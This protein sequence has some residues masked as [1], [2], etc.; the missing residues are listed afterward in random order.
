MD[1]LKILNITDWHLDDIRPIGRK[2]NYMQTQLNQLNEVYDITIENNIDILLI[3]GDLFNRGRV[4]LPFFSKIS[5][6][7]QSFR[8][9][10]YVV[11][12][13]HDMYD[14]TIYT[15]NKTYLGLLAKLGIITL[16]THKNPVY[17]SYGAK[18]IGIQG[19]EYHSKID[20]DIQSYYYTGDKVDYSIVAVH[21]NLLDKIPMFSNYTLVEDILDTNANIVTSGHYHIGFKDIITDTKAIINPK[22]LCRIKRTAFAKT[23]IPYGLLIE[24]SIGE[25]ITHKIKKIELTKS[26]IS[27]EEC[28]IEGEIEEYKQEQNYISE[29]K[30]R[31]SSIN[32][33]DSEL[34]HE[35]TI[36]VIAKELELDDDILNKALK[37]VAIEQ[38]NIIENEGLEGYTTTNDRAILK[39]THLKNFM[40]YKDQT[41]NW[42]K[43]TNVLVGKSSHGKSTVIRA[44]KYNM[45]DERNTDVIRTGESR[46]SVINE[47]D[48]GEKVNR[49]MT[50]STTGKYTI[51][52]V[53][54]NKQ[55]YG[56]ITKQ[57]PIEV[58]NIHQSPKVNLY[59]GNKP[60]DVATTNQ[61]APHFLLSESGNNIA[62]AIG[63][64]VNTKPIDL[65]IKNIKTD[66]IS[67]TRKYNKEKSNIEEL[68]K[69]IKSYDYL[70]DMKIIIDKIDNIIIKRDKLNEKLNKSNQLCNSY[71]DTILILT[72]YEI[73]LKNIPDV[74]K[75]QELL[76]DM[77]YVINKLKVLINLKTDYNK[78]EI[79]LNEYSNGL[80][81]LPNTIELSKKLKLQSKLVKSIVELM[82]LYNKYYN[83]NETLD[84]I[85][86]DL[87]N[88]GNCGTLEIKLNQ[89]KQII[90]R[91]K[92]EINC[93]ND[94]IKV[95]DKLISLNNKLD[96]YKSIDNI[97]KLNSS[98]L[99]KINKIKKMI[100]ISVKNDIIIL[101][102]DGY[103]IELQKLLSKK[104]KET[105]ILNQLKQDKNSFIVKNNTCPLCGS[106][107]LSEECIIN[108]LQKN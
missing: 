16:L 56:N 20:E 31:I 21:G 65:A 108:I 46:V 25:S 104:V 106:V 23:H 51:T 3:N 74:I 38:S 73:E 5:K 63:N 2:D 101:E 11:A 26:F 27:Y 70:K 89:F 96:K 52:D 94:F 44:L 92:L 24:I 60:I 95:T 100:D 18:T 9:K 47:Y 40:C 22:S 77:L 1:K 43:G 12:G 42:S 45:Y 78:T 41:I 102:T 19:K 35:D 80:D 85:N 66:S 97:A 33:S 61:L 88:L 15:I 84:D 49:T 17:M 67:V 14:D 32:L 62:T 75:Q 87:N 68:N 8:C 10:I 76:A 82:S 54:G 13:N 29:F 69:E 4:N 99:P 72:G 79:E 81:K 103:S 30:N 39:S 58:T 7:L 83:A 55:D 37:S 90:V 93:K 59:N 64:I 53:E 48:T 105:E 34:S 71:E 57:F 6:I 28:F 107:G 86:N 36:R 98:M 91:L 50:N